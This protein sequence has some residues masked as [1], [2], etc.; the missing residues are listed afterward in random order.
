MPKHYF[1]SNQDR[2]KLLNNLNKSMWIQ[3][4]FFAT[5]DP[6]HLLEEGKQSTE[7]NDEYK[8][9]VLFESFHHLIK[10]FEL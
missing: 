6:I 4:F 1:I 8:N 3:H 5:I 9:N 7:E 2:F 10:A